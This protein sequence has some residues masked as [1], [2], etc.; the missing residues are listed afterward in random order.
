MLETK[1]LECH[2]PSKEKGKLLMHTAEALLKGGESGPSLV[3]GKP[4]E[5][6]LIKRLVLAPDHDDIM[7]PQ[8]GP[9][10]AKD[11]D[12]LKRWIAEGAKWPQGVVMRHKSAEE[13]K[14]LA[15]LNAKLPGLT[16]LEIFPDKFSLETQR[17]YHRVVVMASF[18]DATTRDVTRF[19]NLRVADSSL[20]KLDG[21][22]I[23]PAADAGAT[24][25]VATLGGQ[26]VKAPIALK[27]GKKDRPVS[28]HLDV[29]PIFLRGG[30]ASRVNW[31][32]VV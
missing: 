18:N 26:T 31:L 11:V 15:D 16:K 17:D 7:P 21:D 12:L 27:D 6:E 3:V 23:K 5:S 10:A 29:M 1:C 20:V 22:T 19:S 25:I 13:L 30:S 8:G 32:A 4:A 24:E 2:N 9:L 28:Y 14:A